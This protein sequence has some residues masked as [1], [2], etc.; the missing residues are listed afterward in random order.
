[1]IVSRQKLVTEAELALGVSQQT[2]SRWESGAAIPQPERMS[3]LAE[4]PSPEKAR[5]VG[6]A[7]HLP[8][9]AGH[10]IGMNFQTMYE[11]TSSGCPT[12]E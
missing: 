12:K 7:G 9:P 5:L 1:L 8:R 4:F 2:V 3:A 6:Y 10:I 11:R